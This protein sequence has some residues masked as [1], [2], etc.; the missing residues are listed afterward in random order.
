MSH[1][2]L[3]T[4]Q[5]PKAGNEPWDALWWARVRNPRTF[6]CCPTTV[7]CLTQAPPTWSFPV[8]SPEP[9]STWDRFPVFV[10]HD[11][12]TFKEYGLFILRKIDPSLGF[13]DVSPE[14]V[15]VV[16]LGQEHHQS[17]A[18]LSVRHLKGV[19]CPYALHWW[20]RPP[21]WV[22]ACLP[23][24]SIVKLLFSPL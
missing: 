18:V 16:C 4:A 22:K 11:L 7:L 15:E 3:S 23:V 14:Q 8:T 24:F 13:S 17:D 19:W 20:C 2:G 12:D 10:S 5:L 6:Y 21:S 1:T 9:A